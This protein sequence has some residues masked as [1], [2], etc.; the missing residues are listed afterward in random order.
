MN[1][2]VYFMNLEPSEAIKAY[3]EEKI[4]K[5]K[6]Y[7]EEP[8]TAQVTVSVEKLNHIVKITL[9][10]H[11][12]IVHLEERENNLYS[13]IDLLSDKLDRKLHKHFERMKQGRTKK[14]TSSGRQVMLTEEVL[15]PDHAEKNEKQVIKVKNFELRPMDLEEAVM[16]M[17]LLHKEFLIFLNPTNDEVN[18]L[19]TRKDGDY[20]LIEAST[21]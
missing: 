21:K 1:T 17:D 16:Q 5:V 2:S 10:A 7:L 12:Y 15:S 4:G 13:A 6:R 3:I 20:G 11:G 14:A 19:Y 8:V 18:V 9:N